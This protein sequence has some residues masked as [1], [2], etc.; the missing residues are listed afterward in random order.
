M[1]CLVG[2]DSSP[3][4]SSIDVQSVVTIIDD[5]AGAGEFGFSTP[6]VTVSEEQSPL[7]EAVITRIGAN[8]GTVTLRLFITDG[9]RD[10]SKRQ[11]SLHPVKVLHIES[12]SI[13]SYLLYPLC[14]QLLPL[15][16]TMTPAVCRQ[17]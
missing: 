14:P 11:Y 6:N 17:Q 8:M 2:N 13:T 7:V 3:R 10:G 16:R 12:C 9:Q 1:V 5:E 4:L 15:E